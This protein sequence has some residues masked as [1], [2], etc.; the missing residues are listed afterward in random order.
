MA[1]YKLLN[2]FKRDKGMQLHIL[3]MKEE[4]IRIIYCD[5]ET[6]EPLKGERCP[7][8]LGSCINNHKEAIEKELKKNIAVSV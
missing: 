1:K 2:I 3:E 8:A 6:L 5:P 7:S 4:C